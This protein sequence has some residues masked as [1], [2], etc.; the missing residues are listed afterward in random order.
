MGKVQNNQNWAFLIILDHFKSL[1]WEKNEEKN[2]KIKTGHSESFL[3]TL[4]GKDEKKCKMIKLGHP[5]SIS[6]ILVGK[7]GE[8]CKMIE[9]RHSESFYDHFNGK[10]LKKVQN[11]QNWVF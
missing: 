4:V 11:N 1:W 2:G 8:K 6:K 3:T 5:E 7:D 9:I 10:R